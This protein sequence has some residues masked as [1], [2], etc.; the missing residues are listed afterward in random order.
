M[1][2]LVRKERKMAMRKMKKIAAM[3]LAIALTLMCF[4]CGKKTTENTSTQPSGQDSATAGVS[5]AKEAGENAFSVAIGE[6]MTEL[7][8]LNQATLPGK[9]VMDMVY[10]TLVSSD[11]EGEYTPMLATKWEISEDGKVWTF[12]L[13][14]DVIFHNGEEFTSADVVNTFNI[15]LESPDTLTCSTQYWTN[16]EGV[17]AVDTYTVELHLNA[18]MASG[19]VLMGIANTYIIPDEA[20]AEYGENMFTDQLMYGSGPWIFDEWVD[21][22]YVHLLKNANYWG[23]HDSAYSEFYMRFITEAATAIN[24]HLSG[25][26]NAYVTT[27]GIDPDL[28]SLY[29]SYDA[30][31]DVFQKSCG[32]F[33]YIGMQCAGA[34]QDLKIRQAF[35][36]AIDREAIMKALFGDGELPSSILTD[37]CFGYDPELKNYVYDSDTARKYLMESSYDGSEIILS[38]NT[39]TKKAETILLAMSEMLNDV[40]FNTKVSI[41]EGATLLEMR[42]TGEYDAFLVTW[43][44]NFGDP[45]MFLNQRVLLDVHHTNYRN[46]RVNELI[47]ASSEE[48]DDIARAEEIREAI[49][50]MR[51]DSAPY[52]PI[53]AVDRGVTGVD[54]FSDGIFSFRNVSYL[55]S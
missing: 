39:A 32:T 2:V 51:E 22:Q 38:S 36:A 44:H 9:A 17:A 11:H 52:Y 4:G 13:R 14:D 29:D 50:L 12:W 31:I 7:H 20:Y 25:T 28:V 41:V 23:A 33:Y 24:A 42:S 10:D 26:V 19:I 30:S 45:Y 40:G 35:E 34:F 15:L 54:I 55:A 47:E 21:G 18:E 8:P 49:R 3:I 1:I 27:G 16:L 46:D 43:S 37:T 53:F 48:T 6:N 5:S